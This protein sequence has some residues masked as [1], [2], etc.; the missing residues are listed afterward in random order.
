MEALRWRYSNDVSAKESGTKD[1][2][3]IQSASGQRVNIE[4]VGKDKVMSKQSQ[5]GKLRAVYLPDSCIDSAGD[6]GQLLCLHLGSR[7]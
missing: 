5:L 1:D 6:E 7:S 4:L 3:Y 2:M